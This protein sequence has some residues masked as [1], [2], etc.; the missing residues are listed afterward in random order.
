MSPF[1]LNFPPFN[2]QPEW[3]NQTPPKLLHEFYHLTPQRLRSSLRRLISPNVVLFSSCLN[4]LQH[5]PT[6]GHSQEP[7]NNCFLLF[8]FF[9]R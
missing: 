3:K 2:L 4:L 9:E 1:F 7:L 5:V 8:L 6:F